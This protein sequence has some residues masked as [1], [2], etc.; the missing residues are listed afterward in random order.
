MPVEPGDSQELG[1]NFDLDL[2]KVLLDV[3]VMP[4]LISPNEDSVVSPTTEVAE[5]AS[6]EIPTVETVIESPGYAVHEERQ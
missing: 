3:S 5:Y 4:T 6:P 2:V 1:D